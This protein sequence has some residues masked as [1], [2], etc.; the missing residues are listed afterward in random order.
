MSFMM[1]LREL[2]AVAFAPTVF[3]TSGNIVYVW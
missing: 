1:G 2:V 3:A